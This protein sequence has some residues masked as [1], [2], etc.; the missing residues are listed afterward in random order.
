MNQTAVLLKSN[1]HNLAHF[2]IKVASKVKSEVTGWGYGKR[3]EKL[4][5]LG[6]GPLCPY[7]KLYPPAWNMNAKDGVYKDLL[8][9]L[10]M[11]LR[12]K[13]Q[14]KDYKDKDKRRGSLMT[15]HTAAIS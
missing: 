15:D 8:C 14:A 3:G 6:Y 9:N 11:T 12:I 1:L 10:E 13:P 4:A 2:Q 7:L 5:S